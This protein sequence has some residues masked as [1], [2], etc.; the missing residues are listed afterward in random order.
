MQSARQGL[1]GERCYPPPHTYPR[2]SVNNFFVALLVRAKEPIILDCF[3]MFTV[4][5]FIY[6]YFT[7]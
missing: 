3:F 5:A 6:N 1:N 2:R 4:Y 7:L